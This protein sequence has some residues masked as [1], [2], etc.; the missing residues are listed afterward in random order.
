MTGTILKEALEWSVGKYPAEEGQ[1][2][3]VSNLQFLFNPEKPE[4]H[5]I[6]QTEIYTA[7]GGYL[8]MTELYTVAMPKYIAFG[9]DGYHMFTREEVKVIVD[10]ENGLGVVDIC[11]QF[12]KR[13]QTDF[14]VNPRRE[15]A[16]QMRLRV[17]GVDDENEVDGTSPDGKYHALFPET[18]GRIIVRGNDVPDQYKHLMTVKIEDD[19]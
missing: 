19:Q 10:D 6:H 11:K 9:G 16:R 15:L 14:K 18:S 3:Q 8:N 1:F 5:R 13:T 17:L 7:D 12:F 2:P 4:G